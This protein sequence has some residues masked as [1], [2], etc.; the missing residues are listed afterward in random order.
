LFGKGDK[1]TSEHYAA[2][3]LGRSFLAVVAILL[4]ICL[5]REIAG[6]QNER[7]E[8]VARAFGNSDP[9]PPPF[10]DGQ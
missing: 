3:D 7:A 4:A 2:F 1:A 8:A 5:V 9:P 10:G 6:C